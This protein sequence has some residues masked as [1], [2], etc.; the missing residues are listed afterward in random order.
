MALE[1]TNDTLASKV[2]FKIKKLGFLTVKG[3]I[4]DFQGSVVFNEKELKNSTV[5]VSISPITTNTG[6]DKRDEHLKSMD[7]F[8]VKEFPK[9]SFKSTTIQQENDHFVAIGKLTILNNTKEFSIPFNHENGYLNATFSIERSDYKL[10]VKLPSFVAANT[11][12]IKI[13]YKIN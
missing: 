7:F 4:T 6:N 11:V 12:Q 2:S 13:N 9:I 3:T 8:Y 10:G 5:D 1:T